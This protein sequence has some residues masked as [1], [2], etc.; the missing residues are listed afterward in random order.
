MS[1]KKRLSYRLFAAAG[2]L[3][4]GFLLFSSPQPASAQHAA[5]CS[6]VFTP[7]SSFVVNG[8]NNNKWAY[9]RARDETGVPWE[10]LAAIHY[11]ETS[12]SHTNPGNGQGIFQF[13]NGEGGPYPA[14]PVSDDEFY[15][16]L[17]FMAN[18]LQDNYVWRGS[19]PR[20]RR[21]LQPNESN[22]VLI[23]DTLF[24]YNGRASAYV[25]QAAHFGYNSSL[26]PY[27]GSPY[28][29]NRFD[30][31]RA[32]MG[33]I[34]RDYGSM[35][36]TDT[37]YGAFTV[38]ARLRGESYWRSLSSSPFGDG[39]VRAKS[40]NSSDPRQWVLYSNI[41]QQIPDSQTLEAW[42]LQNTPLVTTTD[43]VLNSLLTG[44]DLGRLFHQI[45][46]P[47]LYFADSGKKYRVVNPQMR[48]NWGFSGQV[49]SFVSQGLWNVPVNG[50][51]LTYAV[52]NTSSPALYMLDGRNG[53][54]QAV[55]RQY[56][57]PDVFHA[58]EGDA[59]NYI[60]LSDEFFD[61]MD[62][63]IGSLL[64][65][66]TIIGSGPE[67]YHVIAGQKLYLSG[68]M[69]AIFSQ[70]PQTV[71]NATLARLVTSSPV[72][73]FIRMPGNG[74]TIY[75]VDGNGK[76]PI[77]SPDV[78][79]AWSPGGTPNVNILNQG[80]LNLLAN[81]TSV[82]GYAADVSGQ[83]YIMDGRKIPVPGNLDSMYRTGTIF[84]AN[85]AIANIFP[86]AANATI[87]LK[88]TNPEVYLM[89]QG[90]R[91]HIPSV[92]D[93]QL[94]NGM[95]G[96]TLTT[97]NQPVLSQ[98][99]QGA[100]A[101]YYFTT[102]GTNYVMDNGTYRAVSASVATDW[103][104]SDPSAISSAVRDYFT[105]GAA[106]SQR[107]KVDVNYY[108]VKY[109]KTHTTT[110]PTVATIWGITSPVAVSANLVNTL[111]AS[112]ELSIFARSTDTNDHRIFLVDNG[113][114][115]FS[116][117][118]S[119]EQFLSYGYKGGDFIVA[120]QPADLGTV[121]TAKNI[122]KTASADSERVID[123]GQKY[124]FTNNAVRDRWLGSG[125]NTLTVSDA[126][127]SYFGAGGALTGNV[128]GSVPNVYNVDQGGKRWIQ[129][130]GTYQTYA[131]QYGGFSQVS[132]QLIRLL[133]EGSAIP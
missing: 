18:K 73:N 35:D 116:H 4:G 58:W 132:D 82:S 124:S 10:M 8:V 1:Q 131:G 15:R 24:S 126:L 88:G 28:V 19:I 51:H 46:D 42:G 81:S 98:F 68:A 70:S 123:R 77:A 92:R 23:K 62:D 6:D 114:T 25:N 38:F 11:R 87:F 57:N 121:G 71:S 129:S 102:G 3:L 31:P 95:R 89:D 13:V 112:S 113:G 120:V 59:S 16:Q 36:G 39:F 91:R 49:E 130:S 106:L 53:S 84:T 97:V 43:T 101:K 80:F 109:G 110:N 45:G 128:K 12:F 50:G 133:P 96:E 127:W 61:T 22:I 100:S 60:V 56:S 27:E 37:R 67:Q 99:G 33:I 5:E 20:E 63:A 107:A 74:V 78:L 103:G 2:L 90:A 75:M 7:L 122:I 40:D 34:T 54:N 108:R 111:P 47:T 72:T 41:K 48:D 64:T 14:G 9:E 115:S 117:L 125:D 93:W 44:P 29:M 66:Y 85:A 69:S 79:K 55:L 86:T 83:L 32:R 119:V 17:K 118:I 30:C 105:S 76:H 94:W 52:K 21:R 65:G 104:L 26:Q